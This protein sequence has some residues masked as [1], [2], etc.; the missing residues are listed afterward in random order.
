MSDERGAE[1]TSEVLIVHYCDRWIAL[2]RQDAGGGRARSCG[3]KF[4]TVNVPNR[5][6]W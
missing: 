4:G 3:D 2:G 6:K 1:I 5:H